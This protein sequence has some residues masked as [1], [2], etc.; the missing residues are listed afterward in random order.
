[1]PYILA[2]DPICT[3]AD[4]CKGRAA[5][6]EVD[7]II[8]AEIY[9]AQ[10]GGDWSFFFDENNLRGACHSCHSAKTQRERAQL[11]G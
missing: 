4:I 7:H 5:S 3:I 10:N 11:E 1:M 6:T 2:R 9:I 8:R